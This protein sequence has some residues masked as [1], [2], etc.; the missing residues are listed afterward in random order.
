MKNY[1]IWSPEYSNFSGG[2]RALHV[3]NNEL[4]KRDVNSFLHYQNQHQDDNIVLYPEIVT[5]NPMNS[6]YVSRWLLAAGENKDLCFEWVKGLG[7]S[8]SLTVNIIDLDIFYPR[9]QPKKNVGYWIGKGSQNMDVPSNSELI[10]KFE[11]SSRESLAEQLASYEYIISFD[12]FTAINHEATILGT[13]VLIANQTADWS[14]NKL[15]ETGWPVYGIC[16]DYED[17]EKAKNEVKLQYDAYVDFC[18]VFDK[19]VDDFIEITQR[20]YS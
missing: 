16:W 18:K 1:T 11:P 19:S 3:L 6:E 15:I 9:T 20:F 14:K 7:G 13:P 10:R 2:I 8:H 17:L 12:S 5:D 4:R